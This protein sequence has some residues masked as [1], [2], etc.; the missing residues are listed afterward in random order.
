MLAGIWRDVLGVERVGTLD[1][2][3]E[4]GGHSLN[5]TRVISR[6]RQE[7]GLD[8][9]LRDL[10]TAPTV[11]GLAAQIASRRRVARSPIETVEPAADYALS[12]GQRRLWVLEQLRGD[13]PAAYNVPAALFLHGA[14]D[15]AALERA[16]Q[17]VIERH[18]SLRTSFVSINGEPRQ[19][20]SAAVDFHI[21]IGDVSTFDLPDERFDEEARRLAHAGFD[22]TRAPLLRVSLMRLGPATHGL[23][24][25]AHHI[26]TDGWSIPILVRELMACYRSALEGRPPDL[27]ALQIHYKDYAAWQ[28]AH[29]QEESMAPHREY[30]RGVFA[31]PVAPLDLPADF[32]RP[33][34][35]TF[36][37]DQF[38]VDLDEDL[39]SAVRGL[40]ERHGASLFTTLLASVT[41]L[42][43]RT[44]GQDDVT[45]G[46]PIAGRT[47]PSLDDQIGYYVNMVP[48]RARVRRG[49]PFA[50]FL[51]RLRDIVSAAVEH[52]TYPFDRLVEDM[53]IARDLGRS[54]LFDVVVAMDCQRRRGADTAWAAG[55]GAA[56]R[57]PGEQVRPDRDV[58][59]ARFQPAPGRRVR[60][61]HRA[62]PAGNDSQPRR[63]P[64]AAVARHRR[65]AGR[66]GRTT[67]ASSR[68]R[69]Q[70]RERSMELGSGGAGARPEP[71]GVVRGAGGAHTTRH[72]DC[73][74]GESSHLRRARRLGE[75][76]RS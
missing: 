1:S 72:G 12:Y 35:Q 17:R 7:Y 3:F 49:E 44:S 11:S 53:V 8:V 50:A 47:H 39:A 16:F 37:G 57:L 65:A 43:A 25:V 75:R 58:S 74:C 62:V 46:S 70:R 73:V 10:F 31:D 67:A 71:G 13:G 18:E 45:V 33:P 48:L 19:Q 69:A 22:L 28:R 29:L 26:V 54:P 40:A 15:I 64:R 60:I 36:E 4:L 51:Q 27:P 5:A 38:R 76:R 66:G 6:A 59:R 68:A 61:Q 55:G 21:D 56:H 30:W 41:I 42:F 32:P 24:V 34:I 20:V 63:P 9:S 23:A 14:L 2:F 52:Q